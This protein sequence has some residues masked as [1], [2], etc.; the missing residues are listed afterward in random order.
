[1]GPRGSLGAPWAGLGGEGWLGKS[2]FRRPSKLLGIDLSLFY[3]L[4]FHLK[5]PLDRELCAGPGWGRRRTF[6]LGRS[7]ALGETTT[8]NDTK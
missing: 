7:S 5:L 2:A 4:G 1:M 3:L 8:V 6:G